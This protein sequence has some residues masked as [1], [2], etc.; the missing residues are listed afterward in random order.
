MTKTPQSFIKSVAL[1]IHEDYDLNNSPYLLTNR[2]QAGPEKGIPFIGRTQHTAKFLQFLNSKTKKGVFLVT[3]YRGMG[4]TSFVNY[5]LRE[6]RRK[7]REQANNVITVSLTIA[8]NSPKELDILRLMVSSIFDTY[9]KHIQEDPQWIDHEGRYKLKKQQIWIYLLIALPALLVAMPPLPL[10]YRLCALAFTLPA[11][12]HAFLMLRE[13][14]DL[15]QMYR[16]NKAYRRI[17]KLMDRC[18]NTLSEESADNLETNVPVINLK[19]SNSSDRKIKQYPIAG[20]KEIE[21]ELQQFLKLAFEQDKLEFVFV[22]DELD[23]VETV[24]SGMDFYDDLE[25]PETDKSANAYER[26]I[27]DR[28]QAIINIIA[29][30]KN[31]FTT[32]EARFIFIAGNE[33]FDASLADISDRE[34]PISSIFTYV[35]NI[36]SLLKEKDFVDGMGSTNELSLSAG[37]ELYLKALL[38]NLT[39]EEL[40]AGKELNLYQM[41][42]KKFEF[43]DDEEGKEQRA[44]VYFVLQNFVTYLTYRTN[45]SPK[46][47]IREIQEFIKVAVEPEAKLGRPAEPF[48]SPVQTIVAKQAGALDRKPKRYLYFN[49]YNQYRI[50]FINYIYRPFLIRYGR[51]IKLYS[52]NL[53]ISTSYLFDHLIKFHPFAFSMT[54]LEVVPEML[55]SNKT[56][57]LRSHIKKI[58]EY[59]GENHIR[60]IEVGLFDYKFNSR[61]L[62]EITYLSKIFEQESAALNYTLDESYLVKLHVINKIKVLRFIYSKV[63]TDQQAGTQI[64]SIAH[65]NSTLGDL[66]FFDQQY[67]DAIVAYSDAIRP[68]SNRGMSSMNMQDFITLNRT[69]LKIGL[70]FEKMNS[71]EDAL[72]QYSNTCMDAI[73]FMN[74]RIDTEDF[75]HIKKNHFLDDGPAQITGQ[76]VATAHSKDDMLYHSASLSDLLQII[77]QGFLAQLFIQEKK[78]VA[79]ISSIKLFMAL[80]SYFQITEGFLSHARRNHIIKASALLH[81]GNL[82][83]FKNTDVFTKL[84]PDY[85][86]MLTASLFRNLNALEDKF[87]HLLNEN[88]YA[89]LS[90][91][92]YILGILET[93]SYGEPDDFINAKIDEIALQ[94]NIAF[95]LITYFSNQL[96]NNKQHYRSIRYNYIGNFLSAI[97]DNLLALYH[98]P[99]EPAKKFNKWQI[100]KLFRVAELAARPEA[101]RFLNGLENSKPDAFRLPDVMACYYLSAKYYLKQ[102]RASMA[103]FQFTKILYLL[104]L[105][106]DEGDAAATVDRFLEFLQDAIVTPII[107]LVGRQVDFTDRHML[108]KGTNL[109]IDPKMVMNNMANHP[110]TREAVLLFNFIRLKL[111]KGFTPDEHPSRW[112]IKP[113]NSFATQH[114]RIL[115]LSFYARYLEDKV[116]AVTL[117]YPECVCC[118]Q[119]KSELNTE[120]LALDYLYSQLSVL[121]IL[122]IYGNDYWMGGSYLAYIHLR[123]AKFLVILTRHPVLLKNTQDELAKLLGKGSY[124]SLSAS[125]HFAKAQKLYEE[126]VQLHYGGDAYRRIVDEMIYLEDDFNDNAYHFGAALDRYMITNEVFEARIRECKEKLMELG[127]FS[128]N[129][130]L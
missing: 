1:E 83:Y 80:G 39:R 31:F 99:V 81:S 20:A 105:V 36:E 49:Y 76:P 103:A 57:T 40:V 90:L 72:A 114:G 128:A 109:A 120:Q 63:P 106:L 65:L 89:L 111:G 33:M 24:V 112:L 92:L 119:T 44:K 122:D 78:S 87:G 28:K 25:M 50:G 67:N 9:Q 62:N 61:F 55:S 23:K 7:L 32:A 121:Q 107:E 126:V 2:D 52:D 30:L 6:Y 117:A 19:L 95:T 27:R 88:K 18:Y 94:E 77:L 101:D 125:F 123:V 86:Q 124:A 91:Y 68:L 14:I 127:N 118:I 16:N 21:Y 74:H 64:F 70:C 43:T 29:G 38:F 17:A 96:F 104:R 41:A 26:K 51:S 130:F 3:G 98:H 53:I 4:K 84:K 58:I 37:I 116:F 100:S 56:P 47:L 108:Q 22:F 79:G 42:G 8:Q 102:G 129:D 59:L 97:G 5:C 48:F 54:Y 115:D 60:E 45:G 66:H 71:Y 13:R 73:R 93:S 82:M 110:E 75:L 34:S 85:E 69:R 113:E 11:L 35:F 12:V 46:K 10:L 15:S